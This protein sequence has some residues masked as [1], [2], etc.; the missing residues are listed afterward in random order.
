METS[1]QSCTTVAAPQNG[2]QNRTAPAGVGDPIPA[3]GSKID[4]GADGERDAERDTFGVGDRVAAG[5]LVARRGV[6]TPYSFVAVACQRSG[7]NAIPDTVR[8][9]P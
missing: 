7:A 2:Q 3:C 6:V 1:T 5:D 9:L 4:A 8:T